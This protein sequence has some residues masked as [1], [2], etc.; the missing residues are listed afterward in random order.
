M[1]WSLFENPAYFLLMIPAV[2]IAL[3]VHEV[4]HGYAAYLC[5]DN[6]A[7][8]YGR[9]TLNPLRHLDPFGAIMMMLT[10]FGYAKP[11]PVNYR[12]L[13][14]P[15]RDIALV[16]LAGPLSNLLL[17]LIACVLYF[18]ILL[19]YASSAEVRAETV[20]AGIRWLPSPAVMY[21]QAGLMRLLFMGEAPTLLAAF[22]EFLALFASVNV[23]LAVFNLIPLPPQTAARYLRIEYYTRFVFLGIVLVSW[24]SPTLSDILFWPLEFLRSGILNLYQALMLLLF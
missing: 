2:L 10:G 12:N 16:S 6:T 7:K 5:G 20:A 24:L 17:A 13:R 3:V 1:L 21:E 23:G 22:M 15:R 19:V 11:V 14:K 8:A 9:L 18:V 4:S